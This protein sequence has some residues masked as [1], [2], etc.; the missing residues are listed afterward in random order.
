MYMVDKF[1][2]TK[3]LKPSRYSFHDIRPVTKT[4]NRWKSK[5]PSNYASTILHS[6]S[7]RSWIPHSAFTSNNTS[8]TDLH[9]FLFSVH[10]IVHH[11]KAPPLSRLSR[12]LTARRRHITSRPAPP[13]YRGTGSLPQLDTV[14]GNSVPSNKAGDRKHP[15]CSFLANAD[16]ANELLNFG[17]ELAIAK[18]F[19]I[20]RR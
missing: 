5:F 7:F 13:W 14:L 16:R 17:F 6:F 11:C 18:R 9:L 8:R 12:L 10:R 15:G 1:L 4:L 19:W 20:N 3:R 2:P